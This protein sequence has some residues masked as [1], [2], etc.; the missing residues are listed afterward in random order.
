MKSNHTKAVWNDG[1]PSREPTR[2]LPRAFWWVTQEVIKESRCASQEPRAELSVP[3]SGCCL[4][5]ASWESCEAQTIDHRNKP[6][7]SDKTERFMPPPTPT[8]QY[9]WEGMLWISWVKNIFGRTKQNL[10]HIIKPAFRAWMVLPWVMGPW[11][12]LAHQPIKQA[13]PNHQNVIN[14]TFWSGLIWSDFDPSMTLNVIHEGETLQCQMKTVPQ[15]CLLE[16]GTKQTHPCEHGPAQGFSLWKKT[17]T[18][19]HCLNWVQD[20]GLCGTPTRIQCCYINKV[21]SN[22][23]W[24]ITFVLMDHADWN[25]P[26]CYIKQLLYDAKIYQNWPFFLFGTRFLVLWTAVHVYSTVQW[27]FYCCTMTCISS[28][29]I[30]WK[31]KLGNRQ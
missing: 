30:T 22:W 6:R 14:E 19:H 5:M 7:T 1:E 12:P 8:P 21:K 11:P 25:V 29:Y 16:R 24:E 4:K 26:L 28:Q 23:L 2:I 9:S 17:P 18:K 20:L 31:T 13:P 3:E 10:S 15:W 27:R